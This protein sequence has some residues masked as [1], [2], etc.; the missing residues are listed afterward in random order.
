MIALRMEL[1]VLVQGYLVWGVGIT[2]DI[3]AMPTVVPSLEEA[4]VFLAS[5]R[6]ADWGIHVGLPVL[7]R[8]KTSDFPQVLSRH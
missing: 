7:A 4:E 3:P 5:G 1:R 6:I 8:G 2:E